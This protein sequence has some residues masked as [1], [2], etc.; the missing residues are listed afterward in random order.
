MELL[1]VANVLRRYWIAV[2]VGAVVA[3][4]VAWHAHHSAGGPLGTAG[5]QAAVEVQLDSRT[6][7][8]ASTA[9][10]QP[11]T[12]AQLGVLMASSAAGSPVANRIAKT[13]GI[14]S[15]ELDVEAPSFPP[16][17]VPGAPQQ[18]DGVLP[19]LAAQQ[20]NSTLA[21]YVVQLLP[22]YNVPIVAIQAT[23]PSLP[24]ATKLVSATVATVRSDT[25]SDSLELK[26]LGPIVSKS[27]ATTSSRLPKAALEGIAVW[28]VWCV[29]IVFLSGTIRG[30]RGLWRPADPAAGR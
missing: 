27:T 23:A 22:N 18:P 12:M 25:G 11:E 6:P 3:L 5:G 26:Q 17:G 10:D 21:P 4:A 16:L 29:A 2:A 1:S 13:V 28:L 30:L 7:L 14:P 9:G 15:Y 20:A 24:I 8:I 19:Q